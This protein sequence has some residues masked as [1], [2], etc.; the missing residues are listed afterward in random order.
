MPSSTATKSAEWSWQGQTIRY[1]QAGAQGPPILCI[2]GFGASSD[3]WR[4]NLPDLGQDHR[5]YAIDLLGFGY[6]AKPTPSQPLP[7]TFETWSRQVRDFCQDVIGEPVFM[8]AN[9]IG[10]VVAMQA[11]V[12]DPAWVR[13][14]VM[15]DCSLRLLHEGNRHLIPWHQRFSAPILQSLLGWPPF[16]KIFFGAIARPKV[17]RNLLQQAYGDSAAVT[18]ELVD[19]LIGPAREPGAADVFLA[20]VRYSQGPLP[21]DLLPR[22]TCPV[23]IAWGSADPWEP[24]EMGRALADSPAVEDFTVLEGVGHCPMDEAPDQVNP[25]IR[26]WVSRHT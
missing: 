24:V 17:V 12:D 14:I 22:L 23:L 7:Y 1:Q 15:L 3:H 26:D 11:A 20:F 6:S 25:L 18:D 8:A 13:G 16:G 9:S 2:H 10:C 19:C 4:K 21:R 5:V